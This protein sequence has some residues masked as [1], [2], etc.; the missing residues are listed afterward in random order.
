MGWLFT[1][2][3]RLQWVT[4]RKEVEG[5][6]RLDRR[7]ARGERTLVAFWHGKYLPLFTLLRGRSACVFTSQ[8]LRG[9][10]IAGLRRDAIEV[11][12]RRLHD[13]LAAVDRRAEERARGA[14]PGEPTG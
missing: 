2:L 13:A 10:V 4:W 3:L 9:E 7:L 6:E 5:L 14:T 11:W 8:S 12:A 1:W